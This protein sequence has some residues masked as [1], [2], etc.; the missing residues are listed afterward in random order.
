MLIELA[1]DAMGGDAAPD[2]IL[3]GAEKARLKHPNLRFHFFGDES[4]LTALLM[5]Y[6]GLQ[7]RS[8]LHSTS[9]VI[10]GDVKPSAAVRGYH[11]SSLRRA[12]Q[13]VVDG[14]AHGVVSAGNTGAYMALAMMAFRTMSEIDRPAIAAFVPTYRGRSLMLD[15]GANVE[16]DVNNLIQFAIMGAILAKIVLNNEQPSIGILNIGSEDLKGHSIVREVA[17]IIRQKTRLNFYGFVEG[18]DI[19][20]GT[21]DV[22]VTDGFTGNVALKTAE[23]IG[24]LMLSHLKESFQSSFIAKTA[25]L[26]SRSSFKRMHATFDPRHYN[27]AIFLGLNSVAVKSHGNT[28]AL[29]FANAITVAV[30]AIEKE[31]N[32][33]IIVELNHLETLRL[34]KTGEA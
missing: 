26:F 16:C 1:I 19:A 2:V 30:D 7:E 13:A 27:G 3:Q 5:K 22:V 31:L 28:D 11:D 4:K 29:G 12:I 18:N 15:L 34:L 9:E 14:V 33:Q 21:T 20:R 17:R 25:Y 24:Q 23:G 10:H 32:N 6:P 8:T